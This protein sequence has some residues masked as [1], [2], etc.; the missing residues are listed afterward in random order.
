VLEDA[1]GECNCFTLC[2]LL[3]VDTVTTIQ[4]QAAKVA[5]G[6]DGGVHTDQGD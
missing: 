5:V 6:S 3:D 2:L 1:F 4:P